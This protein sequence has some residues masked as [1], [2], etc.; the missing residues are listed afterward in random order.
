MIEEALDNIDNLELLPESDRKLA[1]ARRQ[2]PVLVEE[3]AT[4][5]QRGARRL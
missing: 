1:L 2:R 3:A 4:P 5:V